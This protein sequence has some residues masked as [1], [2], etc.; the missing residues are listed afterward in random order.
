MAIG[1]SDI[2]SALQNG[3]RAIND[4]N[5]TFLTATQFTSPV[6]SIAPAAGTITF[7]S[8]Q[9]NGF[10]SVTTSSGGIYSIPVY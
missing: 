7:T 5:Q 4:L 1:L 6:S 8:S 3:V 2:L 9:A 10:I